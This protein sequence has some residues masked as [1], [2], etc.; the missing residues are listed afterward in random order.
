M[1]YSEQYCKA[2]VLPIGTCPCKLCSM[3]R[4]AARGFRRAMDRMFVEDMTNAVRAHG[5]K[6][7]DEAL[8]KPPIGDE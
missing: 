8:A 6:L 3:A 7:I 1:S 4:R 2:D 5:R